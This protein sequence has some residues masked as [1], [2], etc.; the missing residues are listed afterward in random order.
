MNYYILFPALLVSNLANAPIRDPQILRLGAS[1]VTTIMIGA[2]VLFILGALRPTPTAR[3]G[4]ALQGVLRFNTYLALSI[5]AMVAGIQSLE[6][7]AVYLA[8]SVPSV[9]I[10]AIIALSDGVVWRSP[11]MLVK[12]VGMN[13]LVL[14]CITGALLAITNIGLPF[15]SEQVLKLLAQGSLPLGLL[16]VGAALRPS[17]LGQDILPLIGNALAR[18]VLMPCLAI[19]VAYIFNLS[20]AETLVLLV[21]FTV[22][23]APSSY[24]LT[25]QMGGDGTFMAGIVTLQTVGALITIPVVLH[26]YGAS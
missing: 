16:C 13:P 25:R 20:S 12:K 2:A 9:N 10:L 8:I 14:A 23:T 11:I 3:F 1:A 5:L 24:V 18:L 6:R 15:G 4:P 7:A 22:P 21:F 19:G 26:L 17:A